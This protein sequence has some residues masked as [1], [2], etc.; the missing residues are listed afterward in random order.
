[1]DAAFVRRGDEGHASGETPERECQQVAAHRGDPS[2]EG[3]VTDRRHGQSLGSD[4]D[5]WV[6]VV[7][8]S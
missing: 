8:R 2:D 5:R 6:V 7:V 3:V 1:M 4:H